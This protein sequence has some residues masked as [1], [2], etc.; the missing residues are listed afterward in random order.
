MLY[1]AVGE[2]SVCVELQTSGEYCELDGQKSTTDSSLEQGETY[3]VFCPC[4][5]GLA[6]RSTVSSSEESE[7]SFLRQMFGVCE[8]AVSESDEEEPA[9]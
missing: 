4:A 7:V 1:L 3:V 9:N 5:A 8:V 2:E 6:C